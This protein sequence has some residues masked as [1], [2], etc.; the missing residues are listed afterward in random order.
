MTAE[1]AMIWRAAC[2]MRGMFRVSFMGRGCE[3]LFDEQFVGLHLCDFFDAHCPEYFGFG[4]DD[5]RP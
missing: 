5:G 2:A 1:K 4:V 3:G